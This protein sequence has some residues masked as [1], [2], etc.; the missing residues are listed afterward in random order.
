RS[1]ARKEAAAD[2]DP[3]ETLYLRGTIRPDSAPRHALNGLPTSAG[4]RCPQP[5][6]VQDYGWCR[7]PA[8]LRRECVNGCAAL[9]GA[10]PEARLNRPRNMP[11]AAARS[12]A[13]LRDPE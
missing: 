3:H 8:Y 9:Q 7:S 2:E 12:A 1:V 10:L 4:S 5:R 11:A 13:V 6:R